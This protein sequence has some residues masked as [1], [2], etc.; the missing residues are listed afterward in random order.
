[1]EDTTS[2]L[3]QKWR[4]EKGIIYFSVTSDGTTGLAWI[5]RL[6]KK[7]IQISADA[8]CY[9][10]FKPTRITTKIGVIKGK[11]YTDNDQITETDDRKRDYIAPN[12][13]MA[14]LIR[15]KFSND[16]LRAI[17]IWWVVSGYLL[18][19]DS[20]RSHYKGSPD[21]SSYEEIWEPW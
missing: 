21:L 18:I 10:R 13:E 6:K 15:E 5:K 20:D 3:A 9:L 4:E 12:A 7:G 14:C 17:G 16:E 8:K 11:L 19:N 2:D 1:M